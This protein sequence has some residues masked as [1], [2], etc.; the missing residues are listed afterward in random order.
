[1]TLRQDLKLSLLLAKLIHRISV[2]DRDEKACQGIT[3]SQHY[4]LDALYRKREMTMKELSQELS[5]A[6][7]TL[8]RIVDILVFVGNGTGIPFRL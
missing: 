6:I 4:T 1:M 2:L 5:L 8:T 3:L 7:S